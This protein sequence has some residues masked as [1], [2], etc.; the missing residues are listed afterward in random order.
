MVA[1]SPF[2][3]TQES[4]F[5]SLLTLS[6]PQTI[7]LRHI[8]ENRKKCS[9]TPLEGHSDLL[10]FKY[11]RQLE[12]LPI[13]EQTPVAVLTVGA[14]LLSRSS[15]L[16]LLLVDG[17]WRYAN[18]MIQSLVRR[19]GNSLSMVSLPPASTAYPRYQTLCS[20]P[21]AGLASV[22][23]LFLA[24][25]WTGRRTQGLLDDYYW[26]DLFL[27]KNKYLFEEIVRTRDL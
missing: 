3:D 1:P 9:L 2:T 8:K 12:S 15:S 23:A 25:L 11:P 16:P 4:C 26:A 22:E 17:T 19:F 18:S 13:S 5:K 14:P 7:L 10:F 20:D 24:H 21:E 27:K 6:A